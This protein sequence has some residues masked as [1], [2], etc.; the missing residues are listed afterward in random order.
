MRVAPLEK[1]VTYY[2]VTMIR[3]VSNEDLDL[4]VSCSA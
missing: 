3:K 4:N 2:K 1:Q